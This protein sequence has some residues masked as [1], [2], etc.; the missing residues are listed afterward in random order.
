MNMIVSA[1]VLVLA[2]LAEGLT[3][4]FI[5]PLLAKRGLEEYAK[6]VAL[7]VG[8]G[9]C[10]MYRIDILLDLLDLVPFHPIAG[11]VLS[12]VIVGRGSNYLNDFVDLIRGTATARVAR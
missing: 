12:G 2:A 10:N 6:Y 1:A 4:Y 11:Y 7:L 8:I 5:V 9:L 3:E